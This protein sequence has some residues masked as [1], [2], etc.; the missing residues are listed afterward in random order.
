MGPIKAYIDDI[1]PHFDLLGQNMH[2]LMAFCPLFTYG[3]I[4]A[5]FDGIL[6]PFDLWAL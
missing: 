3:P 1:L 6:P 4:K 2:I 5:D